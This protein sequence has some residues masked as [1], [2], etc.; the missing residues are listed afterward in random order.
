LKIEIANASWRRLRGL[1]PRLQK[2]AA[3]TLA[4]LP[5]N[6]QVAAEQGEFTL[7]LTTDAVVK[8]LNHDWRG[9]DK[10]TNV[11]SFPQLDVREL[12]KVRP[13]IDFPYIGDIAIAYQFM[14]AEAKR[15]Q[16]EIL[17]HLMHLM[18]HGIL[19]IFGYDHV[20]T[21]QANQMERLE[22]EIMFGLGLPDPYAPI[23]PKRA[24]R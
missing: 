6:L 4:A 7:L 12:R 15:E 14:A 2:A 19:H 18:I 9:K 23:L 17:D 16:K 8:R 24:K 1:K 20:S 22:K 10:P 3:M 11:L 13:G 21:K 5:Q